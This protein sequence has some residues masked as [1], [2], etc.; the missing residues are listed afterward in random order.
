VQRAAGPLSPYMLRSIRTAVAGKTHSR[1]FELCRSGTP[2][3]Y[4]R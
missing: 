4:R 3:F 2:K 1:G